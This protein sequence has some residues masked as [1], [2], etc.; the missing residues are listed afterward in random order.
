MG[1]SIVMFKLEGFQ[2]I[3]Q[4]MASQ[5]SQVAEIPLKGS[6]IYNFWRK[7]SKLKIIIE[8]SMQKVI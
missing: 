1:K 8:R 5:G 4:Y 7:F 3:G 6:N 2:I